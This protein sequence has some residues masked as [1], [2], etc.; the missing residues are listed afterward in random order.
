MQ[1]YLAD[2]VESAD[3]KTVKK[4]VPQAYSSLMTAEESAALT[5]LMEA[6]VTEGTGSALRTDVYTA[7]GKTGSAEF[8]KT[9][10]SHAW[11]T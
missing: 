3:G 6:V 11:F 1:P 4:F 9:K 7:A 8:D 2:R 10:E 5:S